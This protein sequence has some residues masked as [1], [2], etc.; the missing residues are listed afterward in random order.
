MFQETGIGSNIPYLIA[1]KIRKIPSVNQR[2]D[3][4]F[5]PL[6]WGKELADKG[7]YFTTPEQAG[8]V[9]TYGGRRLI[10]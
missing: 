1:V 8:A 2:L 7:R 3:S 6:A 9:N 4:P 10:V 5:P